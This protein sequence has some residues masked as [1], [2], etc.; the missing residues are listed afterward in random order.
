M[1]GAVI[2]ESHAKREFCRFNFPRRPPFP[3]LGFSF[4]M[5]FIIIWLITF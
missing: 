2:R 1:E 5:G 3:L 4:I